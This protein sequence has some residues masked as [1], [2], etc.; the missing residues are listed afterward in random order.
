M[1]NSDF[2]DWSIFIKHNID[3]I[4]YLDNTII[5]YNNKVIDYNKFKEDNNNITYIDTMINIL[6][7]FEIGNLEVLKN[8]NYPNNLQ[9]FYKLKNK[10]K[11]QSTSTSLYNYYLTIENIKNAENFKKLLLKDELYKS[12]LINHFTNIE[13]SEIQ[14]NNLIE[15]FTEIDTLENLDLKIISN[16]LKYC[17]KLFEIINNSKILLIK[18]YFSYKLFLVCIYTNLINYNNRMKLAVLDKCNSLKSVITTILNDYNY[19]IIIDTIDFINY[20][21]SIIK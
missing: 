7:S 19:T 15:Y 8:T 13:P 1:E 4:Y 16:Q 2:L 12:E 20:I 17:H 6:K 18:S 10:D 14:V 5:L 21:L 11:I 9:K 3:I